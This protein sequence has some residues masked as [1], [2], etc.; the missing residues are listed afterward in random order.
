MKNERQDHIDRYLQDRMQAEEKARFEAELAADPELAAE[1]KVQE[2]IRDGFRALHR[3][4]ARE[5]MESWKEELGGENEDLDAESLAELDRE[6][7]AISDP[8]PQPKARFPK[9]FFQMAA[10]LAIL[11]T[12]GILVFSPW[13]GSNYDTLAKE[14]LAWESAE[15]LQAYQK[16]SVKGGIQGFKAFAEGDFSNAHSAFDFQLKDPLHPEQDDTLRYFA[17]RC[18]LQLG[19]TGPAKAL[20][21]KVAADSTSAFSSDVHWFLAL[22]QLMEGKIEAAHSALDIVIADEESVFHENAVRLRKETDSK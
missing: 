21:E 4:E 10:G 2:E 16:P 12:V 13:K 17:G 19:K 9:L 6:L 11:V 8:A 7:E 1:V 5:N 18:L 22:A 14:A 15:N 20:F 3:E